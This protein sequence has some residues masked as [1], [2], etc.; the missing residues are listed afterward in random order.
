MSWKKSQEYNYHK[1]TTNEPWFLDNMLHSLIRSKTQISLSNG[2]WDKKVPLSESGVE[3]IIFENGQWKRQARWDLS[4]RFPPILKMF[5]ESKKVFYSLMCAFILLFSIFI[6]WLLMWCDL[7]W[8]DLDWFGMMEMIKKHQSIA[9][10]EQTFLWRHEL[11]SKS[12]VR[13]ARIHFWHSNSPI[14]FVSVQMR[15]GFWGKHACQS[16][17]TAMMF[18]T[19]KVQI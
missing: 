10:L 2:N 9:Q 11:L 5:R 12:C 1:S 14:R 18:D 6:I 13:A 15:C 17:R 3:D 4:G 16:F 7:M 8:C 19:W